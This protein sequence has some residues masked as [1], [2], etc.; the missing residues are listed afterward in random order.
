M[1]P[2]D[3]VST[4]L[5]AAVPFVLVALAVAVIASYP[6]G[7][8]LSRIPDAPLRL[9]WLLFVGV[10]LQLA[11]DL[12]AARGLLPDAGVS[13]WMLLFLSQLL[14][15]VVIAVNWHAPGMPLVAV[16]LVMNAVVMA[17]NGAMPVSPDAIAAL[18]LE[19]AQ[20]PPGKHT[21]MTAETRLPW[22]ADVFPLPILRT[23]ISAGDVVLAAGVIPLVHWMMTYRPPSERRGRAAADLASS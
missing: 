11:V 16:G 2:Y 3:I 23:I 10:G 21:L 14:V 15:V 18:G 1:A 12:A 17:A 7:G 4:H 6:R 20:V 8:R 13:G 9:M 19:G 22:L 5:G